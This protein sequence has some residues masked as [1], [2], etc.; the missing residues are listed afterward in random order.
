M[1]EEMQMRLFSRWPVPLSERQF[2]FVRIGCLI[3]FVVAMIL[4]VDLILHWRESGWLYRGTALLYL[5][6]VS[7]TLPDVFQSYASYKSE[8]ERF[9]PSR[10]KS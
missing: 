8:Q 7:P 4:W 5:A 6:F 2:L 9:F 1:F 3:A 10:T